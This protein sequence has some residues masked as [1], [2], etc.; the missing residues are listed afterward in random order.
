MNT[1]AFDLALKTATC[2]EKDFSIMRARMERTR[3]ERE[4]D[5]AYKIGENS[6]DDRDAY[7]PYDDG[8]PTA[9]AWSEGRDNAEVARGEAFA[10][11]CD[12]SMRDCYE[13]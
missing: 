3:A 5:R 10:D 11:A 13:P 1:H 7:C 2:D 12:P 4:F 9:D 6:I 8:T